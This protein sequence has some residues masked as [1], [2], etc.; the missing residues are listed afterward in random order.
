MI[1]SMVQSGPG[2]L[3]GLDLATMTDLELQMEF[4]KLSEA[5]ETL[6][7]LGARLL[8]T[9]R[10]EWEIDLLVA[11]YQR[12]LVQFEQI[13]RSMDKLERSLAAQ[14]ERQATQR[15]IVMHHQPEVGSSPSPTWE[16]QAHW[17][18]THLPEMR[19]EVHAQEPT[20]FTVWIERD[21]E[22]DKIMRLSTIL[23][24]LFGA[25]GCGPM[26]T[27]SESPPHAS[28]GFWNEALLLNARRIF[29]L[30]EGLQPG[31]IMFLHALTQDEWKRI[32]RAYNKQVEDLPR[33]NA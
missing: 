10:L 7:P 20:I 17:I 32:E 13:F 26:S 24:T 5:I 14:K 21:E 1:E 33:Q 4:Q 27:W 12:E 25:Y 15:R 11:M 19:F 30:P 31:P 3:Q 9:E 23:P 2:Q 29:P 16:E 22:A 18:Q 28:F 6:R 8:S